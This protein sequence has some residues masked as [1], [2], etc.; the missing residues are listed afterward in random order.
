MIRS[1]ALKVRFC[2]QCQAERPFRGLRCTDCRTR[3]PKLS[4]YHNRP[5]RAADGT[6]VHSKG[7]A[8]RRADLELMQ[9]AGAIAGL[10]F[11]VPYEL[12]VGGVHI[13][14]YRADFVY[15]DMETGR[16]VVEDFKGMRT[17]TYALKARLML[18]C[19]GIVILETSRRDLMKVRGNR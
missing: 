19:H 13:A 4:K 5:T 18:A 1:R 16:D 7:E 6:M 3:E 11:Q 15:R 10:L 8:Q 2:V 9:Q 12:S 14:I 17:Q